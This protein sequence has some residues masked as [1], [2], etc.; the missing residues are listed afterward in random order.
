[1]DIPGEVSRV[2]AELTED[3]GSCMRIDWAQSVSFQALTGL[4]NGNRSHDIHIPGA[5]KIIT[6]DMYNDSAA[7]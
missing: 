2:P 1:M 4:V 6:N 3:L 5:P 7:F